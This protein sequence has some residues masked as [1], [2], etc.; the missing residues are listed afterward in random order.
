VKL[1]D[2]M[3]AAGLAGFAEVALVLFMIVFAAVCLSVL[4]KSNAGRLEAAR[5]LPLDETTRRS[6]RERLS[7]SDVSSSPSQL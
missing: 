1:S 3:S 6:V 5:H 4:S 7:A 2:V